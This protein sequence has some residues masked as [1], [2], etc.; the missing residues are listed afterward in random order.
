M[1][2][3]HLKDFP[4]EITALLQGWNHGDQE[5]LEELLSLVYDELRRIAR[6][7]LARERPDHTL[8]STALVHETYL[9]LVD[10]GKLRWRNRAQFFAIAATTMRRILVEHARSHGAAKRDHGRPKLPLIEVGDLRIER[11]P[12][13]IAL[14]DCLTALART[15]PR[16]AS[17]VE[18]RF[19][20]GLSVEE[21]AE[22]VGC[23]RATVIRHWRMAK[24]WL[25][26]ELFGAVPR[27]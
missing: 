8:S 5:S 7:H 9:R 24:A 1:S 17:I 22:V 13:L 26:H 11:P 27:S 10:Q 19:F 18:L 4:G 12:E 2:S 23:S 6:R 3:P 20:G 14:D 16:K 15:D 25:Y 21:T